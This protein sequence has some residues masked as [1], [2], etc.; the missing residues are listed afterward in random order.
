MN[1]LKE[2]YGISLTENDKRK[3]I[4]IILNEQFSRNKNTLEISSNTEQ[5]IE[6]LKDI[7]AIVWALSKVYNKK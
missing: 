1:E 5:R 2:I 4:S 6:A 7:E 3:Q